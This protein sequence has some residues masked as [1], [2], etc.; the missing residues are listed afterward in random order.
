MGRHSKQTKPHIQTR[1]VALRRALLK[2]TRGSCEQCTPYPSP[3]KPQGSQRGGETHPTHRGITR[4]P[5]ADE[6][7]RN[8]VRLNPECK[9]AGQINPGLNQKHLSSETQ[10]NAL[11]CCRN[12]VPRVR[13]TDSANK[14][15]KSCARN[16]LASSKASHTPEVKQR[17]TSR[18]QT[19]L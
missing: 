5:P 1:N 8:P 16:S 12:S 14:R 6:T 18:F 15:I 2:T 10:F 11:T 4:N 7:K 13:R 17:R 19:T 9:E 3:F